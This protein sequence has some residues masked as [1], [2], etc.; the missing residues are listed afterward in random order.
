MTLYGERSLTMNLMTRTT[1][2]DVLRT[3]KSLESHERSYSEHVHLGFSH[4]RFRCKN[5]SLELTERTHQGEW[6]HIMKYLKMHCMDSS[7]RHKTELC[8]TAFSQDCNALGLA[9]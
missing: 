7:T 1:T 3:S 9:V 6:S 4:Q 2:K 5:E 8:R